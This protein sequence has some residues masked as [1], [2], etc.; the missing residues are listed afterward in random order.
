MDKKIISILLSMLIVTTVSIESFAMQ[1][2]EQV[3]DSIN[4]V[5]R[6]VSKA[7]KK[8][9]KE[10]K[11]KGLKILDNFD[12][13]EKGFTCE[14]TIKIKQQGIS[15]D[16]CCD[17]I[18]NFF[19][20]DDIIMFQRV[21]ISLEDAKKWRDLGLSNSDIIQKINEGK[22]LKEYKSESIANELLRLNFRMA[23]RPYYQLY[24]IPEQLVKDFDFNEKAARFFSLM[25]KETYESVD[26]KIIK[27]FIDKKID[28]LDYMWYCRFGNF[29]S[30]EM[31]RL[32][33]AQISYPNA[34]VF[35]NNFENIVDRGDM[36]SYIISLLS[37]NNSISIDKL[38]ELEEK[39]VDLYKVMSIKEEGFSIEQ[40]EPFLYSM[41]SNNFYISEIIQCLKNNVSI[42]VATSFKFFGTINELV[43]YLQNFNL[44]DAIFL[45]S[46]FV[47]PIDAEK[48]KNSGFSVCESVE[49]A[50][51]LIF[52]NIA[53]LHKGKSVHEIESY[54]ELRSPPK[55]RGSDNEED[56]QPNSRIHGR[57]MGFGNVWDDEEDY[58]N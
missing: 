15:F 20:I 23:Q 22:M 19:D 6:I 44:P 24:N 54:L 43:R 10:W 46:K 13:Y 51:K 36:V 5:K 34:L 40:A 38:I 7:N 57:W 49:L 56:I 17:W 41:V 29:T 12:W 27:S 32:K 2:I 18:N 11:Q 37:G 14:Q 53:E 28:L 52:P 39:N 45:K 21:N 26:E 55:G 50:E 1:P 48:Y 16:D 30:G 3:F 8:L 35:K 9:K 47:S 42:E 33:E 58:I 25:K 31:I 4:S